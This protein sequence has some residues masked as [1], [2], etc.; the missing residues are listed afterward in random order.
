MIGK[1]NHAFWLGTNSGAVIDL[2]EP[3]PAE[4]CIE[5]IAAGLS[6]V[7]RFNG[8]ITRHYSVAEHSIH[9]AELVPNR[10][11]RI[12][13]LHDASEAYLCDV[14]TPLKRL[15]GDTYMDIERRVTAAIAIAL[16]VEGL[17]DLPLAVKNADKVMTV[18]E[19]DA[20]T[21][22]P[23]DWGP[24]YEE[25]LRYPNFTRMYNNPR[26][27]YDAFLQRYNEYNN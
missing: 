6:K 4:I 9:V 25:A 18:T 10:Y 2:L 23:H 24:D 17:N 11:K 19:R 5:D 1:P 20:F 3:D 8:Q 13:L 26:R 15:L 16:N 12:A 7:C 14:P 27:A 21:L 22:V